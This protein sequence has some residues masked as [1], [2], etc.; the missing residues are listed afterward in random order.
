MAE[1]AAK[2]F[3]S[4]MDTYILAY[5]NSSSIFFFGSFCNFQTEQSKQWPNRRKFGRSGQP[6]QNPNFS[7]NDTH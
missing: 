5:K 2:E 3:F 6:A 4:K 7:T 1:N